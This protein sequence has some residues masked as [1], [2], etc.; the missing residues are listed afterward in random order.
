MSEHDERH[1]QA[2][3]MLMVAAFLTAVAELHAD[4]AVSDRERSD[5]ISDYINEK[6]FEEIH[7]ALHVG[8]NALEFFLAPMCKH[9]LA[10]GGAIEI[11]ASGD[12]PEDV[13]NDALNKVMNLVTGGQ[14]SK[15]IPPE[16][17]N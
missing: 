15:R 16:F 14:K 8:V 12:T 7:Q 5:R 17:L 3:Q 4:D 2:K 13:M 6:G 9:S 10:Q 11:E 1:M